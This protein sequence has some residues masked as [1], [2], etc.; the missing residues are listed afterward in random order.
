LIELTEFE[1]RGDRERWLR[2][3]FALAHPRTTDLDAGLASLA[4]EVLDSSD[5]LGLWTRP[6][7]RERLEQEFLSSWSSP[8]HVPGH[9]IVL[10]EEERRVGTFATSRAYPKT[11]LLHSLGVDQKERR[12]RRY[13]L[14]VAREL[15]AAML[16][17][18]KGEEAPAWIT[19]GV[20][21]LDRK[22]ELSK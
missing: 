17:L 12:K 3:V 19:E 8:P 14:D 9:L 16:T 5:Y 22:R 11:W 4:W 2:H 13:F 15:Y 20:T 1:T 7:D 21:H 10:R 6:E 18:L